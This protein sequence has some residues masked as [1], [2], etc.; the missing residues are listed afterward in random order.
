MFKILWSPDGDVAANADAVIDAAPEGNADPATPVTPEVDPQEQ[1]ITKI[2]SERIKKEQ[3]RIAT[4]TRQ[5]A[6]AEWNAKIQ[7]KEQ[8]FDSDIAELGIEWNGQPVTT[9]AQ[10]KQALAEKKI[11]DE[12]AQRQIP[13]EILSELQTTKATANQALSKL[14][15]YERKDALTKEAEK[16]SSDPVW[17]NFYKTH[18]AEIK[19][20]AD[21]L[22]CDL[23]TAKLL[24]LDQKGIPQVDE[25]AIE[26]RGIQKYLEK[27]KSYLPVEGS[28]S[29]PVTVVSEPKTFKEAR[30]GALAYLRASREQ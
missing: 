17:G 30:E 21:K 2:V 3:E 26:N 16:L 14:S 1:K 19:G 10:M 9:R 7:A 15:Q 5:A 29:S 24:V 8:E 11:Q 28:G 13:V 12:A 22:N 25:D 6:E 27:K 18:E 4:E 20:I 23:S